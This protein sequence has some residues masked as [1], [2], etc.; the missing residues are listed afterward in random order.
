[1]STTWFHK[2]ENAL[3]RAN[4]LIAIG[5]QSGAL[6]L[7]HSV[8]AARRY[9]TWQKAYETL[10]I[11]Y[12]DLCVDLQKHREAKDGLHQY[13]NM[14]QQQA[15]GSLEVIIS[16]LLDQSESRATNAKLKANAISAEEV[17]Q[18][19]DLEA[20]ASPE[21]IMLST[22]TEEGGKE[23]TDREVVV[24]WLKFL[25]EAYRAVLDILKT[26]TK[27]EHVYHNTCIKA[28]HFCKTYARTT[29]FRRLCDTLRQHI[30]N[31][32][33]HGATQAATRLRGW[34]GWTNEGIELHLQTRFAQLEVAATLELWTE[35]FRTVEDIYNI[36]QISKKVPKARLM[37]SYYDKLTRIFLVSDNHLF[38]AYAWY[39]YYTLS[40]EYNKN[41]TAEERTSQACCVLL[42][43]LAI[44][45]VKH[46]SN[47]G[48]VV[49]DEDDLTK[50]KNQRMATLLGFNTDPS[51]SNL[52]QELV[53]KGLLAQVPPQLRLLY[54]QLEVSCSPLTIV[55]ATAPT[56]EYL[57]SEPALK[58]YCNSLE[59]V[60]VLRMLEGLSGIYQT[61]S[62]TKF[63]SYLNGLSIN[64]QEVEK[65][66]VR[67]VKN[68][69]IQVCKL[70]LFYDINHYIEFIL[71]YCGNAVHSSSQRN[72]CVYVL[73]GLLSY[74]AHRCLRAVYT[75]HSVALLR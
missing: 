4:E 1:M 62:L 57:N 39:K 10:M 6:E 69:D 24:P 75:T 35:G 9:K 20:E 13:R 14:A 49:Y 33:K 37:A 8:F 42:A 27:L 61:V 53:A 50:E 34:E 7:L 52:L 58:V 16:H 64:F 70:L 71:F 41:L 31:L 67:A 2:P 26:N 17:T 55:K 15:P 29:E 74:C 63:K 5:N 68:R 28:F 32:Q 18:I 40:R 3:K 72:G 12:L 44:P 30:S 21:S 60:V 65:L 47:D 36:M 45:E 51:R 43:A 54:S 11:K 25:W 19:G 59:R 46:R 22:M 66:L 73:Y 23:R 38:H 48:S 56:F